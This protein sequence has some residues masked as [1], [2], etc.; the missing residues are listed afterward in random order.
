MVDFHTHIL[1]GIDDGSTCG[2]ISV[3]MLKMLEEQGVRKVLLTPHFYAYAYDAE[4][5]EEKRSSALKEL[6]GELRKE[7]VGID[8][9]LGCE[10]LYFE[11]L[12]RV[13]KL[14]HF[15]ISGTDYILLELPF[16]AWSDSLVSNVEK[17]INKGLIPIIAHFERYI[18][19]KG[20]LE[21][22]YE[23]M[24]MGVLLQMNCK[25]LNKFLTRRRALRFIK[26]GMVLALGTDC[27]NL[28]NRCPDYDRAIA[29]L[30]KK[31]TPDDYEKFS[32]RSNR[33]LKNAQ[34]IYSSN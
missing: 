29:Y 26:K 3:R 20:N 34:K 33:L 25:F 14:K 10:V 2:Q 9:Y 16:S 5:F 28:E 23:M 4:S 1:P 11:E 22:I 8:L 24:D 6:L 12:W 18:K 7:P 13:E 31:L 15:C 17:I 19:Y 27:H 32:F 21:K 30:K